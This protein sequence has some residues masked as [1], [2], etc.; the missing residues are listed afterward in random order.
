MILFLLWCHYGKDKCEEDAPFTNQ[1]TPLST[2]IPRQ[3]CCSRWVLQQLHDQYLKQL[4]ADLDPWIL[5]RE[6]KQEKQRRNYFYSL[7]LVYDLK[8]FLLLFFHRFMRIYVRYLI[9]IMYRGKSLLSLFNCV[10]HD[11]HDSMTA[12]D[13]VNIEVEYVI[14]DFLM[15]SD[16]QFESRSVVLSHW[17]WHSISS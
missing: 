10:L 9:A 1:T 4:F 8:C 3:C 14:G 2:S 6:Q 16:F 13:I 12:F 17:H 11:L 7:K 15:T 5:R